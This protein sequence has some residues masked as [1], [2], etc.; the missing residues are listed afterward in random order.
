M[1]TTGNSA[2][3]PENDLKIGRTNSTT[4]CRE[5]ATLKRAGSAEMQWGAKSCRTEGAADSE[6]GKK[7]TVTLGSLHREDESPQHLALKV[8]EAKYHE[9]LHPGKL[10][11]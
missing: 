8:R 9:F 1:D 6:K 7:Q 4:K 11:A 3:N 5:E 2:N 10:K